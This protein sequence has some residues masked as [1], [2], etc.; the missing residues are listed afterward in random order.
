M[1]QIQ[2]LVVL[3][4]LFLVS[5]CATYKPQYKDSYRITNIQEDEI[6]HSFYLIGDAGN[7]PLGTESETL[8]AFKKELEKASKNSTAIFLGDNIYPNGLPKKKAKE[9][10]FAEHQLNAQ[11]G[12][13]EN[14]KGKT[15]FI[16]GN[17][18]W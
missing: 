17:H 12:T 16:A 3:L 8:K 11:I 1:Q 6:A 10:A 7:S 13:V 18:D 2:S 15:V 9:R 4:I 5:S 14:F